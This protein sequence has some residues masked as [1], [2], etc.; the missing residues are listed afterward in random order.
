MP[1]LDPLDGRGPKASQRCRC[2]LRACQRQ[3]LASEGQMLKATRERLFGHTAHFDLVA[4][5]QGKSDP[6]CQ[7]IPCSHNVDVLVAVGVPL[8]PAGCVPADPDQGAADR[9]SE[10]KSTPISR[11]P[12]EREDVLPESRCCEDVFASLNTGCPW[13]GH[14]GSPSVHSL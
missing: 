12:N 14:A 6:D 3:K 8:A 10:M 11:Q 4:D 1:Q 9:R 13:R 2:H 7:G 5:Q